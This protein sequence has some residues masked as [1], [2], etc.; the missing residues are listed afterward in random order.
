MEVKGVDMN[1]HHIFIFCIFPI[2][3]F[4]AGVILRF[5]GGKDIVDDEGLRNVGI[6]LMGVSIVFS[7]MAHSPNLNGG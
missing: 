4:I 5:F 1:E 6:W 7:L 2:G 3:A